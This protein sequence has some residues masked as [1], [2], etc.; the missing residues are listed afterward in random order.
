VWQV[1]PQKSTLSVTSTAKNDDEPKMT[2]FSAVMTRNIVA[3]RRNFGSLKSNFGNSLNS[4]A[5]APCFSSRLR[6]KIMP[7]GMVNNPRTKNAGRM[8]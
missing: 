3:K 2:A 1:S 6:L 4:S 8:R 7:I 5:V